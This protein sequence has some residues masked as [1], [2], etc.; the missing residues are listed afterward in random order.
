MSAIQEPTL[1]GTPPTPPT[2]RAA[3]P[4]PSWAAPPATNVGL[5]VVTGDIGVYAGDQ[6]TGF[7]PPGVFTGALHAGDTYAQRAQLD[8]LDAYN[9]L[10]GLPCNV[11]LT[12]TNLGGLVL[13]PGVYRFASSAALSN[14]A[15]TLEGTPTLA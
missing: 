10:A 1:P 4:P 15:L 13:A 14:V 6:V 11:E 5:T 9:L 8:L 7:N 3:A 12:D 2:V